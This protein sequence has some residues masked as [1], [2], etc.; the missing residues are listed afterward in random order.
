MSRLLTLTVLL[1]LLAACAPASPVSPKPTQAAPEATQPAAP[2]EGQWTIRMIQSG[3][4]MGLMRVI[5][6]SSDG[7]YTVVDERTSKTVTDKLPAS[8][9]TELQGLL[10]T[11]R[12]SSPVT[13]P[14]VCA[15]C[16][17]YDIEISSEGAARPMKFHLDDTTLS[18][19]GMAELV[20]YLR[21]L[22]D[23]AFAK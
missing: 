21:G 22:M 11:A 13:G 15:D 23:E 14:S 4:I 8:S 5:E 17:N 16:F 7:N 10:A 18:N 19:S 3:G 9:L 6:I 20:E 1:I 2:L 12:L